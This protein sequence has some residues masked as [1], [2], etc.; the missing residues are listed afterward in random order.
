MEEDREKREKVVYSPMALPNPFTLDSF[1]QQKYAYMM[2]YDTEYWYPDLRDFTFATEFMELTI[3]EGKA[4]VHHYQKH[5]LERKDV[6]TEK[7]EELLADLEKRL[8][9][10]LDSFPRDSDEDPPEFFVRLSSRSPKDVGMGPEHPKVLEYLEEEINKFGGIEQASP[11]EALR[12]IQSAAG[13]ILRVK[14][15][16]EALWLIENSERTFGDLIHTM[17]YPIEWDMKLVIRRW[18]DGVDV[19]NE[20]RGFVC[21]GKL[22]ALSQYNDMCYYYELDG[23]EALI[24]D[25]IMEFWQ[26]LAPHVHYQAVIVDFVLVDDFTK[27]YCVEVN[28]WGPVTGC[29]LFRWAFERDL[30]Q[31][32]KDLWDDLG[33]CKKRMRSADDDDPSVPRYHEFFMRDPDRP[34]LRIL[35]GPPPAANEAL[36]DSIPVYRALKRKIQAKNAE[37]EKEKENEKVK[38]KPQAKGN[39][40]IA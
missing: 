11:N 32:G 26:R 37:K 2:L 31:G 27:V 33:E 3:E 25:K 38:P 15:A 23:K 39:C 20:F 6:L 5:I 22:T 30:L 34:V 17:E 19:G 8:Q 10:K 40:L 29:S 16:R 28:P 36:L 1:S 21:D 12:S 7:D 4:L 14:T 13:R 24:V 35:S 9:E 18:K